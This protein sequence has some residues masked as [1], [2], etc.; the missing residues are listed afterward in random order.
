[1]ADNNAAAAAANPIMIAEDN[2][3]PRELE[4]I[5]ENTVRDVWENRPGDD[6]SL[7][8][9]EIRQ[10]AEQDQG[11][12]NGFLGSHFWKDV[13]R[14]MIKVA[15]RD[16]MATVEGMG[17]V[18]YLR[19]PPLGNDNNGPEP[20]GNVHNGPEPPRPVDNEEALARIAAA[21]QRRRRMIQKQIQR[22]LDKRNKSP[23]DFGPHWTF[24]QS[25]MHSEQ[26]TRYDLSD[27]CNVLDEAKSLCLPVADISRHRWRAL[28]KLGERHWM[29]KVRRMLRHIQSKLHKK[30]VHQGHGIHRSMYDIVPVGPAPPN[31][32]PDD[33]PAQI[34]GDDIQHY[35]A[36]T[37][38][39]WLGPPNLSQLREPPGEDSHQILI[40]MPDG[41]QYWFPS[42]LANMTAIQRY[43]LPPAVVVYLRHTAAA[44]VRTWLPPTV[45][46]QVRAQ[47]K[48]MN[49]TVKPSMQRACKNLYEASS[50]LKQDFSMID[51]ECALAFVQF[52]TDEKAAGAFIRKYLAKKEC[53]EVC[54]PTYRYNIQM[55]A[56]GKQTVVGESGQILPIK[57]SPTQPRRKNAR[58]KATPVKLAIRKIHQFVGRNEDGVPVYECFHDRYPGIEAEMDALRNT[59]MDITTA[60]EM[61]EREAAGA[62]NNP[63]VL[64]GG[65]MD[66]DGVDDS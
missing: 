16:L 45:L 36:I 33:P 60:R 46:A 2:L 35:N 15:V 42:D 8:V 3:T 32:D 5:I 17:R 14:T 51:I 59:K 39:P 55:G 41:R 21:A 25:A 29:R 38:T 49:F 63:P 34:V 48:S 1:M 20:P 26:I 4:R 50:S 31:I 58:R 10:Q 61:A 37:I 9:M 28:F 64:D 62:K 6:V 27:M 66:E 65:D 54:D 22:T 52:Q 40:M 23:T 57:L 18:R 56:N 11:W 43:N 7:T 44:Q 12:T 19:T 47:L 24:I 13:S 30:R 53:E